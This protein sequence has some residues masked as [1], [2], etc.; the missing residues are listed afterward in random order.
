MA[1]FALK[2]WQRI[3]IGWLFALVVVMVGGAIYIV[4]DTRSAVDHYRVDVHT[5]YGEVV[6]GKPL[7]QSVELRNVALAKLPLIR[8]LAKGYLQM[9]QLQP[10]Y[11]KL[12]SDVQNFN[13]ANSIYSD[14]ADDFNKGVL[15][16][17]ALSGKFINKIDDAINSISNLPGD[18]SKCLETM[19]K[20]KDVATNS[21][22]YKDLN[23]QG[24]TVLSCSYQAISGARDYINKKK[25]EFQKQF[26][27]IR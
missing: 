13:R 14:W 25:T 6:S 21:I 10:I 23:K 2:R 3:V 19:R 8:K 7:K 16:G 1:K 22:N 18:N 12:I 27:A 9:D 4:R 11:Q 24:D 26:E 5:Q 15:A 20:F 17:K